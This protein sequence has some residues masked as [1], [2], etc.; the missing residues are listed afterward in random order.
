MT[1]IGEVFCPTDLSEAAPA[2]IAHAG[3]LAEALDVP[4]VVYHV[5][6]IPVGEYAAWGQG[7]ETEV[8]ARVDDDARRRLKALTAG[9]RVP[10]GIEVDCD[11][12]PA[13]VLVDLALLDRIRKRTRPQLVVMPMQSR[14]GFSRFFVGSVT[15]EVVRNADVPV[16]AI[17]DPQR[18]APAPARTILVATDLSVASRSVFPAVAA[19][20][21][22]FGARVVVLHACE[23]GGERTEDDVRRFVGTELG[24]FRVRMAEGPAWRA[25]AAA[26]SEE[27]ADAVAIGRHGADATGD[28]L[29]GTTTDRVLRRAPCPVLVG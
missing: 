19:L 29:L 9:L 16:L 15:E 25:L 20:A 4:L 22:P 14:S 27:A 6:G 5:A 17:R 24:D 10:V 3:F 23:A 8:L 11:S 26:A 18:R 21:R 2:G 1:A 7:R 28:G 13:R 12:P